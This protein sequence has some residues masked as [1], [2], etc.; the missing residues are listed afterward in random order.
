M[1]VMGLSSRC[2]DGSGRGG[3]PVCLVVRFRSVGGPLSRECAH[4][5]AM[6][7]TGEGRLGKGHVLLE[8][9]YVGQSCILDRT[10]R[11][12][13]NSLWKAFSLVSNMGSRRPRHRPQACL[14]T[15]MAEPDQRETA[16]Y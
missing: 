2:R 11:D 3:T 7:R 10:V 5:V 13:A 1:G 12:A 8:I 9:C 4:D 16:G 15:S 14:L 6:G